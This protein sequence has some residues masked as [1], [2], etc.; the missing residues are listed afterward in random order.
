MNL[1]KQRYNSVAIYFANGGFFA[2]L[3]TKHGS[4]LGLL[5]GLD[6]ICLRRITKTLWLNDRQPVKV[7][8]TLNDRQFYIFDKFRKIE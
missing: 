6:H 8:K 2:L 1:D 5:R 4:R 3:V 7:V